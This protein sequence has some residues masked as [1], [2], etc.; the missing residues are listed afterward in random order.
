MS[1]IL[2]EFNDQSGKLL[3]ASLLENITGLDSGGWL[4]LGFFSHDIAVECTGISPGTTVQM[5]GFN[6]LE[7]PE[8]ADDHSQL[9][10]DKKTDGMISPSESP[11][12]IKAKVSAYVSGTINVT[13]VARKS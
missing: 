9:G 2:Q 12:W 1:R 3:V 11:L 10:T 13:L 7:K 5:F 8:D 6:G 4:F